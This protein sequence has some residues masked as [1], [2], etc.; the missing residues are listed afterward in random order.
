MIEI[1]SSTVTIPSTRIWRLSERRSA[2][3]AFSGIMKVKCK[4]PKRRSLAPESVYSTFEVSLLPL[5]K[6]P[7]SVP[8][9]ESRKLP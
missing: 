6:V 4:V 7:F 9:S 2:S 8:R 3:G 1:S 5:M